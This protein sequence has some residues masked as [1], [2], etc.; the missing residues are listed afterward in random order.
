[1]KPI[2]AIRPPPEQAEFSVSAEQE[3]VTVNPCS[4][5]TSA[6]SVSILEHAVNPKQKDLNSYISYEFPY[7]YGH[8]ARDLDELSRDHVE[9]LLLGCLQ[10]ES[11]AVV[12][13]GETGSGKSYLCGTE[14]LKCPNQWQG[15]LGCYVSRRIFEMAKECKLEDFHVECSMIEIYKES[16]SKEQVYDLLDGYQRKKI[17]R[18]YAAVSSHEILSSEGLLVKLREGSLLRNTDRT[19]GNVRSSRSHAIFTIQITHVE[20]GPFGEKRKIR[21]KLMIC[22]LAGAE[23]AS[24]WPQSQQHKQGSGINVGLSALQTVINDIAVN[25]KTVQYRMSR[26]T[27]EL[28][29]AL[30][31]SESGEGCNAI[32]IGCI[33]PLASTRTLNTLKYIKDA[34]KIKNVVSKNIQLDTEVKNCKQ[35]KVLQ[36][37]LDMFTGKQSGKNVVILNSSE[38]EGIISQIETEKARVLALEEVLKKADADHESLVM[39]NEKIRRRMEQLETNKKECADVFA[40]PTTPVPR[41]VEL[42]AD[43]HES[44]EGLQV[45]KPGIIALGVAP[46]ISAASSSVFE[47]E[48]YLDPEEVCIPFEESNLEDVNWHALLGLVESKMIQGAQNS[49]A[50][51]DVSS[52]EGINRLKKERS[53]LMMSLK[54]YN[55]YLGMAREEADTARDAFQ[56]VYSQF[57]R[58]AREKMQYV[59]LSAKYMQAL[60]MSQNDVLELQHE[61]DVLRSP[62]LTE[63]TPPG[64]RHEGIWSR[65][66]KRYRQQHN[67]QANTPLEINEPIV[68][69][70]EKKEVDNSQEDQEAEES[71][72]TSDVKPHPIQLNEH[73]MD[74]D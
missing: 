27:Y 48:K 58:A 72:V 47:G 71:K 43:L 4:S 67:D 69:S 14:A 30:G 10:G 9:P 39:E 51:N 18:S 26:L 2:I 23:S 1:M 68:V 40:F 7:V 73:N 74:D 37:K 52:D 62:L 35:C 54:V 59:E 25:G 33:R 5:S 3:A 42:V 32:F 57:Q 45:D 22:D 41:S 56:Q 15:S 12:A 6:Y 29:S 21:G 60:D 24:G 38:Y 64:N 63:T 66:I 11:A 16:L 19:D 31:S 70:L 65:I 49:L 8:K 36:K 20:Q 61:V 44:T 17:A 53:A 13:Y 55:E 50:L 46:V 34:S 28:R